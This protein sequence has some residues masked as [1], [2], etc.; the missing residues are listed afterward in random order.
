MQSWLYTVARGG[1]L[2]VLLPGW[3][4]G[5]G[6][7]V[8]SGCAAML[9]ELRFRAL[10]RAWRSSAWTFNDG[11]ISLMYKASKIGR[12]LASAHVVM[13]SVLLSNISLVMAVPCCSRRCVLGAPVARWHV[14][15]RESLV[16][17]F[18]V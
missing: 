13:T 17:V 15:R 14:S 5:C 9:S 6:L 8:I 16:V 2:R 3:L 4:A 11:L 18:P 10:G 12:R 1:P 7:G